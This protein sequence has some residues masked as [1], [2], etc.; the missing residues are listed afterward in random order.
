MET[1]ADDQ[2]NGSSGITDG[3]SNNQDQDNRFTCEICFDNVTEPVLTQCGHLF[4][5]P[6]LEEVF[7]CVFTHITTIFY[8]LFPE[9]ILHT[10]SGFVRV[11]HVLFVKLHATKIQLFR[12]MAEEKKTKTP[13]L[14]QI[15]PVM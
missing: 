11:K 12:F 6:C 3:A 14:F 10:T 5:W 9:N 2:D 7:S 1:S 4:C 8:S 13:G 15:I